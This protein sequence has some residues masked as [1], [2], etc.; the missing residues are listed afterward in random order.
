M[1]LRGKH[2]RVLSELIESELGAVATYHQ[3]M[4]CSVGEATS[5]KNEFRQLENDH[6]HSVEAL[7]RHL[8]LADVPPVSPGQW[9]SFIMAMQDTFEVVDNPSMIAALKDGEIRLAGQYERA[10]RE[11]SLASD[12]RRLIETTLLPKARA[13]AQSLNRFIAAQSGTSPPE[14]A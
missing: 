5:A 14:A 9:K 8:G 1:S 6:R 13:H 4:E 11:E 2:P 3:V 7:S 12:L 10:L